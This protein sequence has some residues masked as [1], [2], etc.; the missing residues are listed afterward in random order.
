MGPAGGGRLPAA[1][2]GVELTPK[3]KKPRKAKNLQKTPKSAQKR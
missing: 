1:G 2:K 3:A